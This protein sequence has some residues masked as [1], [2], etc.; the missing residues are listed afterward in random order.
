MR[1]PPLNARA[2]DT[3][4]RAVTIAASSP[5]SRPHPR[6]RLPTRTS[7]SS[8]CRTVITQSC[9]TMVEKSVWFELSFVQ[10]VANTANLSNA[11]GVWFNPSMQVV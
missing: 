11:V 3:L 6:H 8:R 5:S 4:R 9:R 10:V 1:Q 7:P 2:A